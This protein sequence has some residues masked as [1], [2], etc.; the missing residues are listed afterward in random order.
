MQIDEKFR[1]ENDE[2]NFKLVEVRIRGENAKEAGAERLV[3]QGYYGN[4]KSALEGYL[5]YSLRDHLPDEAQAIMDKLDELDR[6]V[7]HFCKRIAVHKG[8]DINL[9][10]IEPTTSTSSEDIDDS[11]NGPDPE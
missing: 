4:L 2:N 3:V 9:E 6:R 11:D 5:R 1:I 8:I 7:L 10:D